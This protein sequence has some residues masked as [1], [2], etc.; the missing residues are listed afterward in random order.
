[1]IMRSL[2]G[3]AESLEK[4]GFFIFTTKIW[5]PDLEYIARAMSSHKNGQAW[6]LSLCYQL[7]ID[8]L[9][10]AAGFS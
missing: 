8:Q 5:N 6:L 9:M 1:M 10:E 3:V 4:G 2:N 7:E